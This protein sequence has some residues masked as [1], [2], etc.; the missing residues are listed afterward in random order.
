MSRMPIWSRVMP[1]ANSQVRVIMHGTLEVGKLAVFY[2]T[3]TTFNRVSAEGRVEVSAVFAFSTAS[4]LVLGKTAVPQAAWRV[5]LLTW[6][7]TYQSLTSQTMWAFHLLVEWADLSD[8]SRFRSISVRSSFILL[9]F[10]T[11]FL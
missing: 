10:L 7:T 9:I 4:L 3:D 2:C 6:G 1:L 5:Q 8:T 11:L